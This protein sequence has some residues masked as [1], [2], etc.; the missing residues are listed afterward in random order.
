[1]PQL[2]VGGDHLGCR[3]KAGGNVGHVASK[4]SDFDGPVPHGM[5]KRKSPASLGNEPGFFGL[6][7]PSIL[8]MGRLCRALRLCMSRT[9]LRHVYCWT[10]VDY[11]RLNFISYEVFHVST[12]PAVSR[13]QCEC[14]VMALNV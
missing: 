3:Y 1:M 13:G 2:V 5:V 7:S 6:E 9:H 8:L 12:A 11:S 10:V 4:A 14:V